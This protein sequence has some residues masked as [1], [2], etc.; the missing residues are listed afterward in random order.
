M[1]ERSKEGKEGKEGEQ[2]EC[3]GVFLASKFKLSSSSNESKTTT[4]RYEV[5]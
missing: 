2:E 3:E 4:V 5:L 1:G